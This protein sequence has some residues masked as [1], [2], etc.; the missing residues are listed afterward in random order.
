MFTEVIRRQNLEGERTSAADLIR[1]FEARPYGWSNWA[2]L[3]FLGRLYRL[4]KVE[5]R[6]GE[7]LSPHEVID[8]LTNSRRQGLVLVRKQEQIDPKAINDLKRFHQEFFGE[9]SGGTDSR[10]T[11]SALR[12]ALTKE[13]FELE[14]IASQ[15][16]RYPFLAAIVP[17][18][19][20][21]R[22]LSGKDDPYLLKQQD[23]FTKEL[24]EQ[25]EDTL[26][27][28]K[29]FLKGQQKVIYEKV[30]NFLAKHGDDLMD[31]PSEQVT[32]LEQVIKSPAPYR[33][34]LLPEANTAIA[35][36]ETLLAERLQQARTEALTKINEQ[37]TKLKAGADFQKLTT[38][39]QEQVLQ[40]TEKVKEELANAE[41]PA[42]VQLRL[43]RFQKSDVPT[44]LQRVAT[45]AAP[46]DAPSASITVVPASSLS[47]NF[48]LGQI[49]DEQELQQWLEALRIAALGELNQGHRISV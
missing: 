23:Q 28:I 2:T 14:A 15:Q 13:A 3:T 42:R 22:E 43:D 5:L 19:A 41:Q 20:R 12:E 39:Q 26:S 21:I 49:T 30:R 29:V 18:A 35:S 1:C 27:P 24:V 4:G 6:E 44:L 47:P 38:S 46:A 9:A 33:G 17:I 45:L 11:A 37:E 31:L 10:T 16:D 40:D 48:P 36:L 25:Q 32:A 34:S 8:A 7:I